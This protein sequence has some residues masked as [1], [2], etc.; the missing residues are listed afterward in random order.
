MSDFEYITP[1]EITAKLKISQRQAI[2]LIKAL[3]N[4]IKVGKEWRAPM[5]CYENYLKTASGLQSRTPFAK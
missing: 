2:Q 5:E 1:K 4:A 3:P